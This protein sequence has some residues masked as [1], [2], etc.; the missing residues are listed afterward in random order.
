MLANT[1]ARRRP[2]VDVQAT[3]S[4][5]C[6]KIRQK[7]CT[8][9][10]VPVTCNCLNADDSFCACSS[11]CTWLLVLNFSSNIFE[12]LLSIFFVSGLLTNGYYSRIKLFLQTTFGDGRVRGSQGS[13]TQDSSGTRSAPRS[14]V[15]NISDAGQRSSE[16]APR[17]DVIVR[18]EALK[19]QE[20]VDAEER[21]AKRRREREERLARLWVLVTSWATTAL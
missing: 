17:H 16:H 13:E 20:S 12:G 1:P 3:T 6:F 19:K 8:E 4:R 15:S 7:L 18:M 5:V 14:R 10:L 21:L 9:N 2:A 11:L